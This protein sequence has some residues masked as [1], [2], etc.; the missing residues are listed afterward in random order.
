MSEYDWPSCCEPGCRAP[1]S[2]VHVGREFRCLEEDQELYPYPE[3]AALFFC[4]RH[5]LSS[6]EHRYWL[7]IS[8]EEGDKYTFRDHLRAKRWGPQFLEWLGATW[9]AVHFSNC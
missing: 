9:P 2:H 5:G 3:P 8:R 1:A 7:P 6:S 4:Q